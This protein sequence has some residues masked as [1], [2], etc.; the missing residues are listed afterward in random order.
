MVLGATVAMG[1]EWRGAGR[2]KTSQSRVADVFSRLVAIVRS[3][4]VDQWYETATR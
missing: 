3:V 4:D 2:W 1:A